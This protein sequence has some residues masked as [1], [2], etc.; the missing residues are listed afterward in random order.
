MNKLFM[1]LHDDDEPKS[2]YKQ[3][4]TASQFLGKDRNVKGVTTPEA[5]LTYGKSLR[6]E[7]IDQLNQFFGFV[8]GQVRVIGSLVTRRDKGNRPYQYA[9]F[10]MGN[11]TIGTKIITEAGMGEFLQDYIAG[12]V[13][14]NFTLE[15]LI[16]EAKG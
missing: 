1:S 4:L 3:V 12:K 14:I 6:E 9:G 16:A 2:G 5:F 8:K 10:L 11:A 15:E 13:T 7:E